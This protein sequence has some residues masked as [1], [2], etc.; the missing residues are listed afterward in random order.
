MALGFADLHVGQTAQRSC[1]LDAAAVEAFARLT[2]DRAPVHFDADHAVALGFKAPIAHGLL[3]ASQYSRLLGEELPGPATVIMKFT[4]DMV[5][6]VDVGEVVHYTVRVAR[7]SE[8]VGAVTVD[9]LAENERRE[10]VN[11]GVAVCV[12]RQGLGRRSATDAD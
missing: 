8:A 3:V 12:F 9:L 2:G 1:A 10:V 11:R 4:C 7:L 5:K 6:P